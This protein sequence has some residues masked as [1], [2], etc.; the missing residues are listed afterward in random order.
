MK[1]SWA[2]GVGALAADDHPRA[3]GPAGQVHGAGQLGDLA[4]VA[5][6]AVGV[7][8]RGPCVLGQGE[9]RPADRLGQIEADREGN[10]RVAA[11]GQEAMGGAGRVCADDDLGVLDDVTWQRFERLIEHTVM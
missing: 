11:A 5:Q 9:N 10:A 7:E 6:P 8:R 4:V 2:P 1:F 3:G